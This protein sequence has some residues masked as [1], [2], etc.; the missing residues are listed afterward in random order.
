MNKKKIMIDMD[1]V[2]CE[3]GFLYLLNEF[4]NTNYK[5]EDFKNYY[6][7][8]IIPDELKK[9]FFK[10]LLAKNMYNY[11]SLLP[12]CY[13]T[14]KCLNEYYDI[15]IGTS[16]L[17]PDIIDDCGIQLLYKHNYLIKELPFISPRKYIFL[18]CKDFLTHEIKIDDKTNHLNNAEIKLL[19]TAPHNKSI[20]SNDLFKKGIER[21]DS[22]LDIK[23][24]LL[25]K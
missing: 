11:S 16:Y 12:D 24:R 21:M 23:K 9:D 8:E 14:L 7:Q 13:D 5:K 25:R 1:D 3:G 2:I 18:E 19:F 10:Y 22:W 20:S 15:Y 6:L 17:I 4:L